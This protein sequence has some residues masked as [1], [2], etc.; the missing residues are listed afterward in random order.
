MDSDAIDARLEAL[1]EPVFD[2]RVADH[3]AWLARQPEELQPALAELL[4]QFRDVQATLGQSGRRLAAGQSLGDFELT[5]EIGRGGMG[6]VWQAHQRSLDRRV[7]LKVLSAELAAVPRRLLRFRREAEAGARLAHPA[8]VPVF[9]VGEDGG[10]HYLAQELVPG[11][12]TL[13]DD[14][15]QRRRDARL[16]PDYYQQAAALAA[17]LAE[18][19]HYAHQQGVVH[20]DVK[21]A[22]VL[23]DPVGG[24]RLADFGLALVRGVPDLTQTGDLAGTPFYMA[25]EQAAGR[26][27]EIGPAT[28]QYALGV[29]LYEVLTLSRPFEGDSVEQVLE[30]IRNEDPRH[31]RQLRARI[32][33]ELAVITLKAMEK[34]PARRYPDAGEMAADL[35]RFLARQPIHARP[36]SI[37][38]RV[39]KLMR[40]HPGWSTSVG[41]AAAAFVAIVALLL[42]NQ[43]ERRAAEAAAAR[44]SSEARTA[45][46]MVQ[47]LYGLLS[48]FTPGP[49]D[50][51]ARITPSQL[52]GRGVLQIE[53]SPR[54]DPLARLRLTAM[55]GWL[56]AETGRQEPAER[57]LQN[58]LALEAEADAAGTIWTIGARLQLARYRCREGEWAAAEALLR[59]TLLVPVPEP[60]SIAKAQELAR[61]LLAAVLQVQGRSSEAAGSIAGLRMPAEFRAPDP[62]ASVDLQTY[63]EARAALLVAQA[64]AHRKRFLEAEAAYAAAAEQ[65]QRWLPPEHPTVLEARVARARELYAANACEAALA[66]FAEV[67]PAWVQAMARHEVATFRYLQDWSAAL[68]A[69]GRYRAGETVL[70]ELLDWSMSAFGAGG[71]RTEAALLALQKLYADPEAAGFVTPSLGYQHSALVVA[72]QR[73]GP[74]DPRTLRQIL[75]LSGYL[76]TAQEFDDEARLLRT[77]IGAAGRLQNPASEAELQEL[78]ARLRCLEQSR[79][80]VH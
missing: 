80:G 34:N 13:A 45:E 41:L 60:S 20:R 11:G 72:R 55:Y 50:D 77:G 76:H 40:R 59:P 18:A 66:E 48:F 14:I 58:A 64:A 46:A 23:L 17:R 12:R 19:L 27:G 26:R 79:A 33:E 5:A 1:L 31:P 71:S 30:R 70:L 8:I 29:T 6:V 68:L 37:G 73:F 78:R 32:P 39:G 53:D 10:V 63:L 38:N 69:Q 2:G 61:H 35:R 15:A 62:A 42:E 75:D 56:V 47:Q 54:L 21:P 16:P 24:P 52:L 57:I 74:G 65:L 36:P 7:A 3:E 22:N 4:A 28:D 25:P 51:E 67:H 44:A 49:E 9:A 43:R